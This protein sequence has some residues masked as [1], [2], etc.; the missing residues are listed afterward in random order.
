MKVNN[1]HMP[2]NYVE[3]YNNTKRKNDSLNFTKYVDLGIHSFKEMHKKMI[4]DNRVMNER[5]DKKRQKK[6]KM[7]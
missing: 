7:I 1:N 4:D 2:F 6:N 3:A 5:I